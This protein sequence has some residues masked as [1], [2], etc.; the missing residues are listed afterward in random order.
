M[1]TAYPQAV[2]FPRSCVRAIPLGLAL[3]AGA[4]F[5]ALSRSS[6]TYW[7]LGWVTLVP[8]FLC[9]RLF[10]PVRAAASGAVWGVSF[11]AAS[12]FLTE[13]RVPHNALSL[14]LLTVVPALY[15]YVAARI[16]RAKG[17]HPLLL[18]LG[19]AGVELALQPLALRYGLLAGTLSDGWFLHSIGSVGGYLLVAFLVAMANAWLLSVL[20]SVRVSLPS[21]RLRPVCPDTEF[22]LPLKAY[23]VRN[24]RFL[25][26]AQARAPPVLCF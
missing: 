8:L 11:Y 3:G 2:S 14:V 9:I 6:A 20:S 12:A 19:W 23:L 10:S 13:A 15:A 22:W 17:F 5:M 24:T 1:E 7:W 25:R 26:P 16:T 4:T 21:K 18:G